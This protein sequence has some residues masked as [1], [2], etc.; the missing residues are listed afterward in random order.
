MIVIVGFLIISTRAAETARSAAQTQIFLPRVDDFAITFTPRP[1][2]IT[3]SPTPLVTHTPT[4][5]SSP[6]TAP[7]FTSTATMTASPSPTPS[8]SQSPT[9]TPTAT[10][11]STRTPVSPVDPRFAI[12]TANDTSNVLDNLGASWWYRFGIHTPGGPGNGI[13]Q[14][15]L[16]GG[17]VPISTIQQA[18][19]AHPG[20]YWII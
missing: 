5:M 13:A 15:P 16:S 3:S 12:I 14:I 10:V 20:S 7:A 4:A 6:T 1:A 11:T 18:A 19:I 8:P 17:R 9:V 2:T